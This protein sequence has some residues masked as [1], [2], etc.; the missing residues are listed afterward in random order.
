M[1]YTKQVYYLFRPL[2]KLIDLALNAPLIPATAYPEIWRLFESYNLAK[3]AAHAR[4][5]YMVQ[6]KIIFLYD[7]AENYKTNE[8]R[9]VEVIHELF[10][11]PPIFS[12]TNL[13]KWWAVEKISSG[14]N[15]SAIIENAKS[16]I[17]ELVEMTGNPHFDDWIEQYST[18]L[19][20][21]DIH[22]QR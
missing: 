4:E 19:R 16:D 13:E 17:F 22:D 20:E 12:I 6:I 18:F 1:S 9:T 14:R 3:D 15:G 11:K 7:L 10:G 8:K 5:F 2:P 21:R